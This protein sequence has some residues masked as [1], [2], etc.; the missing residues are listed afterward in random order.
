[1]PC[2]RPARLASATAVP[3]V[4]KLALVLAVL[5]VATRRL[6]EDCSV[7]EVLDVPLARTI[8]DALL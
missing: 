1:M 5:A 8:V 3:A 7:D 6:G 2:Q 4:R